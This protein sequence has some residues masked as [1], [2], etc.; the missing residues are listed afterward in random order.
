MH[1]KHQENTT[2]FS[3]LFL[4]IWKLGRHAFFKCLCLERNRI[5]RNRSLIEHFNLLESSSFVGKSFNQTSYLLMNVTSI[6]SYF[7][8]I[9]VFKIRGM[10]TFLIDIWTFCKT[11]DILKILWNRFYYIFSWSLMS[12]HFLKKVQSHFYLDYTYYYRICSKFKSEKL[13]RKGSSSFGVIIK[14]LWCR[15]F[16]FVFFTALKE[17]FLFSYIITSLI[18][19]TPITLFY[20][21]VFFNFNKLKPINLT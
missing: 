9:I 21:R 7:Q 15:T 3:L 11:E 20:K 17:L 2:D 16:R 19:N 6:C 5:K 8:I 13:G 10:C 4:A 14:I 1:L 18:Q 12:N